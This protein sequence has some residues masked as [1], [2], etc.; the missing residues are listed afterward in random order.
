MI[1]GIKVYSTFYNTDSVICAKTM[2]AILTL[3]GNKPDVYFGHPL[4]L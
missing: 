2:V 3:F 1:K 4:L